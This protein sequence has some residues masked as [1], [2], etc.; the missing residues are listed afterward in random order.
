MKLVAHGAIGEME[1]SYGMCHKHFCAVKH[2]V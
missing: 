1:A 2:K